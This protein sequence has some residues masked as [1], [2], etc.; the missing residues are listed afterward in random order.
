MEIDKFS[1]F[2][3]VSNVYMKMY[4]WRELRGGGEVL[5]NIQQI[6]KWMYYMK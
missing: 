4:T 2:P 6:N 1:D 5:K 3:C